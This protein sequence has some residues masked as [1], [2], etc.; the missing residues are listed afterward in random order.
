MGLYNG[1]LIELPKKGRAL[2][3]T[4]LHGNLDDFISFI[5]IWKDFK[6][7]NDYFIITGDLIHAMG[8]EDDRSLELL[9]YV[10]S[11]CETFRKFHL[12]LGNHEWATI[13]DVS[14]YK[15]GV[16]QTLSFE[17]LL[18][19]KFKA[20]WREKLDEYTDFLE[21]L[22]IAVKTRNKVFISHAGPPKDVKSVK[23]LVNIA[24]GGYLGN[25]NLFQILWNRYGDYSKK[26]LDCFL[27]V[28]NCNAMIVGHTPVDGIKLIGKKQL[29]VSSSYSRGKKAYVE[30]DLRE[31][32]EDARDLLKMVK[33]ISG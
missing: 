26:D 30:L 18:K 19:E 6:D 27:K 1:K 8:V 32:I 25:T 5:Q 10:K 17:V 20:G 16:N 15:G 11:H 12:L 2:I 4:D 31:K 28:V 9:D 29:I 24:E 7:D 23:D 22:P 14:I 33:Y 3:V 13:S 21:K